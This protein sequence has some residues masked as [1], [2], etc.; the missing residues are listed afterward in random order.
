MNLLDVG[1]STGVVAFHLQKRF[2]CSATVIDPSISELSNA[3][4]L[5]LNVEIGTI[6][7]YQCRKNEEF[8][9][10]TIC[11]TIDHFLD[12][13]AAL[14]KIKILMHPEGFIYLDIVDFRSY[15]LQNKSIESSTKIDHPYYLTENTIESYL[16]M[17]GFK[18]LL[19]NYAADHL[20]IGYVCT[21]G[22][23]DSNIQIKKSEISSLRSEIRFIQNQYHS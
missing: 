3:K 6:E 13:R 9:L 5:G 11:Q 14:K 4:Q 2:G 15:Y 16:A 22:L 18:V 19:K 7:D 21:H 1:G 20:H 23:P 8:D 12:I 17:V 10:V